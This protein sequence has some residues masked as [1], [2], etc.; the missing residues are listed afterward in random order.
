[1]NKYAVLCL[2]SLGILPLFG[3]A[4]VP[5]LNYTIS[6]VN[7]SSKEVTMPFYSALILTIVSGLFTVILAAI[8]IF[9][10]VFLI[11]SKTRKYPYEKENK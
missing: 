4:F 7:G 5:M 1:M 8:L 9:S 2:G 3:V 6:I 10:L 11:A